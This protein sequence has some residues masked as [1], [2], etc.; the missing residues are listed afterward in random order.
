MARHYK[1]HHRDRRRA[2]EKDPRLSAL[3]RLLLL[4]LF[5]A[6]QPLERRDLL[7]NIEN[8][9]YTSTEF[10]QEI[11]QLIRRGLVES[12]G[13]SKLS[14]NRAAP[15]Y[16]GTL[17]MKPAG[18][19]FATELHP[20]G[21]SKTK[22][23]DP[24]IPSSA[25]SSARHGDRILMLVNLESRRKNPEAEVLGCLEHGSSILTGFFHIERNRYVVYPEDPRFPF[26][27]TLDQLPKTTG[28]PELGDV[29]IVRLDEKKST[30]SSVRGKLLEILGNPDL[31]EVQL[32]MV[33]EKYGLPAKFSPQALEDAKQAETA[34]DLAER[35][36]LRDI[37]HYT[38]DGEDAK[39]FD[40]AIAVLKLDH[41]YRLY[42]SIA[43]VAAYVIPGSRLDIEAYERGTSTYFPGFVLPMLPENLSN[44]LCSLMADV[45]RLTMTAVLDFDRKGML[46]KKR[47]T[48]SI[49]RSKMRFTYEIVKRIIVDQ[50]DE[51]RRRFK[52]FLTP[53]K[54]ATELGEALQH[55]R[56]KRGSLAL[57]IP[58]AEIR[59]DKKGGVVAIDTKLRSF[60]N[61]LIEE[62]M[63]AANEAVA[64]T[65]AER[66]VD[67]LYRIHERPD[68]DKVK[69]FTAIAK[70]FGLN[71]G[72]AAPT[73]QWYNGLV[74]QVQGTDRE[75]IVNSL[76]LRTLQQAR[77]S[78]ENTGHFGIGAPDYTHFTSPIRR[79]P[80]LIVH[81][82][83][84]NLISP[85]GD[86]GKKDL[87]PAPY[88]T[89]KAAGL[90]LSER[91]RNSISA[92]REMAE[93]L[94]CRYMEPRI[95]ERFKAIISSLSDTMFFV[96]LLDQFVSGT[97]F[98][99]SLTDD[100]YLHDWKRHRLIGDI[101]GKI[102][103]VGKI[104]EVELT[105]VDTSTRK[106]IFKVTG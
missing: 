58:E 27:I 42:V 31:P 87:P 24:F 65:F 69:D 49:I 60:A 16:T 71:P 47:F 41:G 36:D 21:K 50:D 59:L 12:K 95:G 61:Q 104:I 32:R 82:L 76:L 38:I 73:P 9:G 18:F 20:V 103:Q 46:L 94:K 7:K 97:V 74:S 33:T 5:L 99:S 23:E 3:A 106:I 77:Y 93:R 11:A 88:P 81:R 101:T 100:H 17:V 83:L 43:D 51:T 98:L 90:H 53:L 68:P 57:T 89:L 28:K 102:F 39:D 45:D 64:G 67:L 13:K 72:D 96:E 26:T 85:T 37:L 91:E 34:P 80:D 79:Y 105:E 56:I 52:K 14:L 15:L 8:S 48:R 30:P 44:N 84:A 35:E 62:F 40:D 54:W 2:P 63:L 22:L 75:F 78:S 66:G 4:K 10:K 70:A 55:Q 19:G 25:M 1:K 86:S 29:V 6:E 92:E